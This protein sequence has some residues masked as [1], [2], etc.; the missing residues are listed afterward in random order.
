M[1]KWL[2]IVGSL[3]DRLLGIAAINRLYERGSLKGLPPFEFAERGLQVLGVLAKPSCAALADRM[4]SNVATQFGLFIFV[5]I[6]LLVIYN[7]ISRLL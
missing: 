1:A 5:G 3:L 2:S 7:D 6:F 4:P